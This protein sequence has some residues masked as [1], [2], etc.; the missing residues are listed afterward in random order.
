MATEAIR[1]F[2]R[3]I[4]EGVLTARAQD[5]V[6]GDPAAS[7]SGM[8]IK[9]LDEKKPSRLRCG[10]TIGLPS[11]V[12]FSTIWFPHRIFESPYFVLI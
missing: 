10:N 4:E 12:G 6:G 5:S 9:V 11:P 2:N 3:R 7:W 8:E 1:D